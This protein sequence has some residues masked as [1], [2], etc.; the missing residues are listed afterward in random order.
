M[1]RMIPSLVILAASIL[2][3][4]GLSL[5]LSRRSA[6]LSDFITL[7]DTAADRMSYSGG[8]LAE[9]FADNFAGFV[10]DPAAPFDRQWEQMIR[11]LRDD[12]KAQ[13]REVLIRFAR[14][15]GRGDVGAEINRIRLYQGLL[16]ERLD[17][18]RDACRKKGALYRVLP[19]SAGMA[20]TI[21]LL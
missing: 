14:E 16:R 4:C 10:F 21:L 6:L 8:N 18:A 7:L 11:S 5:R 3:G 9:V 17:D 20:V 12:L 2:I 15:L 1:L 19:F 13:D